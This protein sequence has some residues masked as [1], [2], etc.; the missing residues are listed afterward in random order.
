MET[1]LTPTVLFNFDNSVELKEKTGFSI[2]DHLVD[3]RSKSRYS[4][5]IVNDVPF[6]IYLPS[7]MS[8]NDCKA[9]HFSLFVKTDEQLLRSEI[10][11]F[12]ADSFIRDV[13]ELIVGSV[14]RFINDLNDNANIVVPTDNF[15]NVLFNKKNDQ[16]YVKLGEQAPPFIKLSFEL[17]RDS[18]EHCW[19]RNYR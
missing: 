4:H 11:V 3:A 1:L 16:F 2:A 8:D 15:D 12:S 6:E 5:F 14:R 9:G 13:E 10:Y 18:I 7:L 19:N 17:N